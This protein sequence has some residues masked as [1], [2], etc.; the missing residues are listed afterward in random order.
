[1]KY[2]FKIILLFTLFSSS[3]FANT[4]IDEY[5]VDL[6]YANGILI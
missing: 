1:M 6:Y 4:H 3:L 5:K 2:L